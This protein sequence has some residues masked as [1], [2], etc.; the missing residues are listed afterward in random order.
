MYVCMHA[1]MQMKNCVYALM[2][3]QTM[4]SYDT[5]KNVCMY[6]DVYVCMECM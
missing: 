6:V 1:C 2:H 5:L 4:N 3:I